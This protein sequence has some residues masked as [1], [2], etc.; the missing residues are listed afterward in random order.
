MFKFLMMLPFGSSTQM[1]ISPWKTE[2]TGSSQFLIAQCECLLPDSFPKSDKTLEMDP[3]D[4]MS[5][6]WKDVMKINCFNIWTRAYPKGNGANLRLVH[7]VLFLE[8]FFK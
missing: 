3:G 5:Q 7:M 4:K 6:K 2:Y 8:N 1:Q